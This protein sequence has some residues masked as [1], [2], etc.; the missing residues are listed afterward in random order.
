LGFGGLFSSNL[1]NAN[2][3]LSKDNTPKDPIL[4]TL[5]Y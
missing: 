1:P 5:F 3:Y 4:G 2:I